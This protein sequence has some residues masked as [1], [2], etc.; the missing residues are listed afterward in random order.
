MTHCKKVGGSRWCLLF[1]REKLGVW[2]AD[3]FNPIRGWA[4][5]REIAR[6]MRFFRSPILFLQID[7]IEISYE[8]QLHTGF[9]RLNVRK[10]LG[11]LLIFTS[12]THWNDILVI[13]NYIKYIIINLTFIFSFYNVAAIKFSLTYVAHIFGSHYIF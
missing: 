10:M 1:A 6:Y 11:I 7:P 5:W 2:W 13:V 4:K 3:Y 9:Q 12:T 8:C